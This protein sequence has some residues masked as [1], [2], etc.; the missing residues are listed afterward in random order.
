MKHPSVNAKQTTGNSPYAA[1]RSFDASRWAER[2]RCA[3]DDTDAWHSDDPGLQRYARQVCS[4]CPV[5]VDCLTAAINRKERHGIWGGFNTIE[6]AHIANG[7]QKASRM[8]KRAAQ[9]DNWF[10]QGR[11]ADWIAHEL[12]V[13]RDT[14][15]RIRARVSQ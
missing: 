5:S 15:Y 13:A 8:E 14:V 10:R 3:G 11:S 1:H 12:G 6:R 7:T 9:V 4:E 2:A